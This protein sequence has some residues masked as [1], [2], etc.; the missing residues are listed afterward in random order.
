MV[1]ILNRYSNAATLAPSASATMQMNTRTTAGVDR[2]KSIHLDF[3]AFHNGA[4]SVTPHVLDI[5][6]FRALTDLDETLLDVTEGA[7]IK[8][9][10]LA[11]N[12]SPGRYFHMF[13]KQLNLE[14][15]YSLTVRPRHITGGNSILLTLATKWW[16]IS[17]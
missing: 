16:E 15:G 7:R 2:M 14:D 6:I 13:I 10:T 9:E 1:A 11:V 5:E 17:E 4:S 3:C 12:V 8:Y